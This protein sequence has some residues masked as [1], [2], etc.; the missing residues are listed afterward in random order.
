[1]KIMDK[2]T[3]KQH[4]CGKTISEDRNRK[5]KFVWNIDSQEMLDYCIETDKENIKHDSDIK[6]AS[7]YIGMSLGEL[8]EIFE[9]Y[10]GLQEMTTEE[11]INNGYYRLEMI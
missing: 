3:L 6:G 10:N 7:H 9:D 8:R 4:T 5:V 11:L 1:M 2:E